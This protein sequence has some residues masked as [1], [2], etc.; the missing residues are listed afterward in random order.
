MAKIP[1]VEEK[2]PVF[3]HCVR[4]GPGTRASVLAKNIKNS[5]YHDVY[6]SRE[7]RI[8]ECGGCGAVYHQLVRS[9]SDDMYQDE[10]GWHA[11]E[12]VENWPTPE[13]R[14]K[15]N[16]FEQLRAA[17][18]ALYRTVS[19]TY[20]AYDQT[21]PILTAI[22]VRTSFDRATEILRID[23]N[24][25]FEKK[26]EALVQGGFIGSTEGEHINTLIHA[27]N[28]AAHRGWLPDPAELDI[29][30]DILEPF[31][32]RHFIARTKMDKF[33]KMVPPRPPRKKP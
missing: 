9:N 3:G 28:A 14:R 16:W 12:T 18:N 25:T 13:R 20:A 15:P 32:H 1:K 26:V 29:A 10:E 5:E 17:D 31:L 24:L 33:K 23:P 8:V 2:L 6:Y 22:G 21:L 27:G 11:D 7:D 19:E 30:F 4:C